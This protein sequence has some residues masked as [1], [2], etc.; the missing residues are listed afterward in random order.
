MLH[1]TTRC[2]VLFLLVFALGA[3]SPPA[4]WIDVPFV[5]QPR[6]GCGAASVSMVMR[7][8]ARQQHRRG[9][10]AA[11]VADIQP[12]IFSPQQH[13]ATRQAMEGYFQKHGYLAFGIS[14]TWQDLEHQLSRGRPVIV[15]LRPAGQSEL[16]YVVIAGIDPARALVM[17]NDPAQRKLLTQ[18]RARFEK[19][20]SATHD[21]ML[22]AVPKSPGP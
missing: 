3:A 10:P 6:D 14:G 9:S 7:Y 20:W 5:Q 4:V 13:G 19:D 1:W 8:W 21:W 15:A 11:D 16:H 22:L 17:M 2:G 18:E 12:Q